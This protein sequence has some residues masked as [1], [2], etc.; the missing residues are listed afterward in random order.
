MAVDNFVS[1]VV[2]W[3][4]IAVCHTNV[5]VVKPHIGNKGFVAGLFSHLDDQYPHWFDHPMG[6]VHSQANQEADHCCCCL[7]PRLSAYGT[8]LLLPVNSVKC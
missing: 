7:P 4:L 1:A 8:S 2:N 5:Q 6:T 3:T